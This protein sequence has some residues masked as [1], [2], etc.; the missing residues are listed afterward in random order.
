MSVPMETRAKSSHSQ[1]HNGVNKTSCRV[2]K[3]ATDN[4]HV[5]KQ[6]PQQ[7]QPSMIGMI[8]E[9]SNS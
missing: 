6:Q 2:E 5:Q 1:N 8:R 4:G 7:N 9:V 3:V